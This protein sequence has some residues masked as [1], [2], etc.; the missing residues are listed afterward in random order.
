LGH[1][2]KGLPDPSD[3]SL[4]NYDGLTFNLA[5]LPLSMKGEYQ[6]DNASIALAALEVI[7]SQFP[8]QD[9]HIRSGLKKTTWPGRLE[10]LWR[11]E[12][13]NIIQDQRR[14]NPSS[15][16]FLLDGAHNPAGASAL[17]KSL[18][19]DFNFDHLLL[20]W[21]SMADKDMNGTLLTIAPLADEII[22]TQPEAER[23][24]APETL[25]ALLPENLQNKADCMQN[26][27]D[28]LQL[29]M[30]KSKRGSMI[31]VAGSLYLIGKVRQILCGELV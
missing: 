23:S 21:A 16:H 27:N 10:E 24:A 13:G 3:K 26:V 14:E 19:H 5:D 22:F 17:K 9:K 15:T 25:F 29:A 7:G 1:D 12:Q 20:I 18:L 8:I 28:A 2:F 6:V 11:D 31:C 4:W 30:K